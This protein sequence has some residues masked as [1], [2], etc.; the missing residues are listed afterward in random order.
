M[1]FKRGSHW[2]RTLCVC[3]AVGKQALGTWL[4]LECWDDKYASLCLAFYMDLG[5]EF[6]PTVLAV[7]VLYQP[8]YRSIVIVLTPRFFQRIEQHISASF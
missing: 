1:R 8:S 6:R 4:T 5:V 2:L 7:Q 3:Q